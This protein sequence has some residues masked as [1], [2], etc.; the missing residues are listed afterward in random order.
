MKRINESISDMDSILNG[1]IEEK[2]FII[3]F[4]IFFGMINHS[5]L[6]RIKFS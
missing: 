2:S 5:L 1:R 3:L 6:G 4:V